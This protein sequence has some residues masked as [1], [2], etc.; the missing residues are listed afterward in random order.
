MT[1]AQGWSYQMIEGEVVAGEPA[2]A[3]LVTPASVTVGA[4]G[5][6]TALACTRF[7]SHSPTQ[8]WIRN[9]CGGCM[10]A[11]VAW[12]GQGM[13]DYRVNG[14]SAIL[15]SILAPY[16]ELVGERSC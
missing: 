16:G 9:N 14:H 3:V 8:V 6:A 5:G 13:R 7:V 12:S 15:I 10:I 4:T 2:S 1:E 11:T